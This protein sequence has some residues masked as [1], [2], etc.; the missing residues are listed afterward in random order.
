[1]AAFEIMIVATDLSSRLCVLCY[2]FGAVFLAG[3][4]L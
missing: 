2:G 1:L 4:V 3:N